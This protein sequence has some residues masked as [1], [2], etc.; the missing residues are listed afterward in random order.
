MDNEGFVNRYATSITNN[1]DLG[2]NSTHLRRLENHRLRSSGNTHVYNQL[3]YGTYKSDAVGASISSNEILEEHLSCA[4]RVGRR[5]ARVDWC[6]RP[7]VNADTSRATY[8]DERAR[9]RWP[10]RRTFTWHTDAS[11][12]Q[13]NWAD[14]VIGDGHRHGNHVRAWSATRTW[15]YICAWSELP[16]PRFCV[17]IH[18]YFYIRCS[19][20]AI[21]DAH[22]VTTSDDKWQLV[23]R[24]LTSQHIKLLP[25]TIV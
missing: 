6:R 21:C 7:N 3:G 8:E 10:S 24:R 9:Q 4:A 1:S 12:A 13:L 19:S 18:K 22:N 11:R 25:M 16:T 2:I 5:S 15:A 14:D 17:G 20:L 23:T